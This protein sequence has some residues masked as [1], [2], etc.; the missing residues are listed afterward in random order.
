MSKT[1]QLH[2]ILLIGD[3]NVGKTTFLNNLDDKTISTNIKSTIFTN[4]KTINLNDLIIDFWDMPGNWKK[5]ILKPNIYNYFSNIYLKNVSIIILI[6][7]ISNKASF[8][9]LTFW[10]DKIFE[11]TSIKLLIGNTFNNISNISSEEIYSF[12]EKYNIFRY[13]IIPV[14]HK[15]EVDKFIKDIYSYLKFLY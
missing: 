4:F 8:E 12:I 1:S 6:F 11:Q 7:D 10:C 3:E 14:I 15:K 13:Y 9:S 2:K 5:N